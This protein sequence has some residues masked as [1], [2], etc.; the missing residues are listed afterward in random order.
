MQCCFCKLEK[1]IHLDPNFPLCDTCFAIREAIRDW[2]E[3]KETHKQSLE[4]YALNMWKF[5]NSPGS[6]PVA[7]VH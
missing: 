4:E 6:A 7:T 2:G 3:N 1:A 5:D